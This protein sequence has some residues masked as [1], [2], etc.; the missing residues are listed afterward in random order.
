MRAGYCPS[1][2]PKECAPSP[3]GERDGTHRERRGRPWKLLDGR[4]ARRN[5]IRK[6]ISLILSP[7][8]FVALALTVPAPGALT[9]TI[10]LPVS[11]GVPTQK[12]GFYPKTQLPLTC[13]LKDGTVLKS[14][15]KPDHL[16]LLI[17]RPG[18]RRVRIRLPD[19]FA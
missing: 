6:T 18:L 5:P 10:Q 16:E 13:K 1:L 11:E 19:E 7:L 12:D 17:E 9:A 2:A 15:V 8:G 4:G 14:L 3:N